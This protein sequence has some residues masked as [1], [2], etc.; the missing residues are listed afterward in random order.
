MEAAD[1]SINWKHSWR[2]DSVS[3]PTTLRPISHWRLRQ[4][5]S[6]LFHPTFQLAQWTTVIKD[7]FWKPLKKVTDWCLNSTRA[8][9]KDKGCYYSAGKGWGVTLS[10][11]TNPKNINVTVFSIIAIVTAILVLK[12]S[13]KESTLIP[14]VS[15]NFILNLRH[16]TPQQTCLNRKSEGVSNNTDCSNHLCEPPK[17]NATTL[18]VIS[19]TCDCQLKNSAIISIQSFC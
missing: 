8:Q 19:N 12:S 1:I 6:M 13:R 2:H 14:L 5:S 3:R 15:K 11:K 7:I 16:F 9:I 4:R 18:N 17:W 10:S